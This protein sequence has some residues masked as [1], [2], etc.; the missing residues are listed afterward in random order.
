MS[1]LGVISEHLVMSDLSPLYPHEWTSGSETGMSASCQK[2]THAPQQTESLLD[3]VD[4]AAKERAR[5]RVA[6]GFPL[7]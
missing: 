2:R 7:A 1:A 6:A 4:G 3:Q 5:E